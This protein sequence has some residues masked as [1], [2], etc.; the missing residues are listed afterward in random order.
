MC[1][2]SGVG[3]CPTFLIY[4]GG[5]VQGKRPVGEMSGGTSREK[6][7]TPYIIRPPDIVVGRLRFYYDS[8]YIHLLSFFRQLS[9]SFELT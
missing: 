4:G 9:L 1:S 5:D 7:P 6:C 2:L 3:K 8:L